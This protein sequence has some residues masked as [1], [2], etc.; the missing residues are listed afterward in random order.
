[1]PSITRPTQLLA[2]TAASTESLFSAAFS[3]IRSELD[4]GSGDEQLVYA[5]AEAVRAML[6]AD[7]PEAR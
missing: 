5:I 4:D 1:V 3:W 6:I 7:Q 2:L